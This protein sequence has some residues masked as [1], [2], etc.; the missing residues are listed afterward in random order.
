MK[1]LNKKK[2]HFMQPSKDGHRNIEF[3]TVSEVQTLINAILDAKQ[4]KDST[5]QTT[6]NP[7][8]SN[9]NSSYFRALEKEQS[10]KLNH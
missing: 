1:I 7:T 10:E 8:Y 2:T 4:A 6:S 3:G 9:Q 5:N